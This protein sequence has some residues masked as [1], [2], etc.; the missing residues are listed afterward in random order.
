[1]GFVAESTV[2]GP[3]TM[4][5]VAVVTGGTAGI[6]RATVRELARRDTTWRFGSEA[7]TGFK[8]PRRTSMR[9]AAER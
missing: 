5:K 8:R 9:R 4:P 7:P 2:H 6:G 3:L 1:M